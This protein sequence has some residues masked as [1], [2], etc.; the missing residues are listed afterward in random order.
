[1]RW[2][3]G[4]SDCVSLKDVKESYP[5]EVMEYVISHKIQDQPA[6]A[7][8]IPFVKSKRASIISKAATKYWDRT[9]KFGI[10]VPKSVKEAI[11]IDKENG[12]TLW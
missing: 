12:N 5:I 2:K 9:H 7:W 4:S 10:E 1:M 6:F 3:E 11:R 8:W